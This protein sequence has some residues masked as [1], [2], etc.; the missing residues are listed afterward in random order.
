MK[1]E[2]HALL[3]RAGVTRRRAVMGALLGAAAAAVLVAAVSPDNSVNAATSSTDKPTAVKAVPTSQPDSLGSPRDPL[4]LQEWGY[5]K[6]LAESDAS[7]PANATDSA[8]QPGVEFL[9]ANVPNTDVDDQRRLAAVTVYDYTAGKQHDLM[10]DLGAG[11]VI[12]ATS[13]K[14]VQSPTTLTEAD[15]A[16]D[17]LLASPQS[18]VIKDQFKTRTGQ[19]L[20]DPTQVTYTG[21]SFVADDS[22]VGA[23]DCGRHRCIQMQIQSPD[24][25]YLTTTGFVVDLTARDV[26]TIK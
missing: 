17:L 14:N 6:H 3:A 11:Q 5:A 19:S 2:V 24:G 26:I 9:N 15:E 10:V 13:A 8:G 22:V 16:M 12:K 7:I 4:S 21:G 23:E 1:N 20:T 25:I 18:E